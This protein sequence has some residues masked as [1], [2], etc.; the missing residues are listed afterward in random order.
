MASGFRGH[1]ALRRNQTKPRFR[2]SHLRTFQQHRGNIL[3]K[4]GL[5][6]EE[7]PTLKVRVKKGRRPAW[8]GHH[9]YS[10]GFSCSKRFLE[11]VKSG[12]KTASNT[13]R[14]PPP[15]QCGRRLGGWPCPQ[16]GLTASFPALRASL[17]RV[18]IKWNPLID[19]DAAQNQSVEHVR[20]EKSSNF[21]GTCSSVPAAAE[22]SRDRAFARSARS[23]AIA[24]LNFCRPIM[25][26]ASPSCPAAQA[27][28]AG[29]NSVSI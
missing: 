6:N 9:A 4:A 16:P 10:N 7:A 19:K 13:K 18:P 23:C 1:R 3:V 17:E 14:N 20:I 26:S 11:P 24:V 12:S 2:E 21:F 28:A 22:M 29:T 15:Q 5:D 27:L 25:A 8:Q